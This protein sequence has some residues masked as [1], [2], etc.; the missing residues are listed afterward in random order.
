[1]IRLPAAV[2]PHDR[3][4][5]DGCGH[6]PHLHL[7]SIGRRNIARFGKGIRRS[8]D[9]A[10][11]GERCNPSRHVDADPAEVIATLC[12][13]GGVHSDPDRRR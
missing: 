12:G 1:M 7:A 3:R 6:T 5:P 2:F 9:L 4:D 11:T 10:A 13:V 8:Q